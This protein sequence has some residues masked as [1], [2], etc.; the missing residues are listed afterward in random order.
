MTCLYKKI[1]VFYCIFPTFLRRVAKNLISASTT[2][3]LKGGVC[4]P[5]LESI[6]SYLTGGDA[7]YFFEDAAKVCL[8]METCF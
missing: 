7:V 6:F 3:S 8:I 2:T 4:T 1:L 5:R